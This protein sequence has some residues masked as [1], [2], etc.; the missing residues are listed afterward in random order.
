MEKSVKVMGILNVTPDSFFDGGRH[1]TL[2][3]ALQQALNMEAA[4]ADIIDIGGEST[5][6]GA[7]VVSVADELKRVIPVIEAIRQ[8][9]GIPISIDT[10][11]PEVMQAAV[12]AGANIINDVRALCEPGALQTAAALDVP[13]CL[14][15]MQGQPGTMQQQPHYHNVVNEVYAFLMQ[16]VDDCLQ[17]GIAADKLWIDPGFGFGK[18]LAHNLQLMRELEKFTVS[19]YPVLVGVSRKSMIGQILDAQPE[20]RLAG[21]LALAAL[22]VTKGVKILR[23]HDVRETVD[24]VKICQAV[25]GTESGET[26]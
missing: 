15:H 11:K 13:V 17:A 12:E 16:R 23:V 21:S 9:S 5:R 14:M 22:A 24:V 26:V 10:S 4:G 19:P 3:Q 25:V 2:D 20:E 7:A 6:P 8:R 18:T 1:N